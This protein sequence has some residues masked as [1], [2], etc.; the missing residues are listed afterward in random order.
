MANLRDIEDG[1]VG[2]RW[3]TDRDGIEVLRLSGSPLSGSQAHLDVFTLTHCAERIAAQADKR[4]GV[5]FGGARPF[6]GSRLVE[7]WLPVGHVYGGPLAHVGSMA[8]PFY[9]V[10]LARGSA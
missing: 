4:A 2:D 3:V 8:P 10:G 1:R 9:A 7:C 6:P 5:G